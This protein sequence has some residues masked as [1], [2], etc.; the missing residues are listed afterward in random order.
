MGFEWIGGAESAFAT[1]VRLTLELRNNAEIICVFESRSMS[2]SCDPPIRPLLPCF[3]LRVSEVN[4]ISDQQALG[5]IT[6]GTP[7]L[8]PMVVLVIKGSRG[9]TKK[10]EAVWIRWQV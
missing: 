4:P 2:C 9:V 10:L 6:I 3:S 5:A 1:A 7:P 8:C